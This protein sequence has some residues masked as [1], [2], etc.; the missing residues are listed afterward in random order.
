MTE[1]LLPDFGINE[2]GDGILSETDW[3]NLGIDPARAEEITGLANE[4]AIQ[5][6]QLG[7]IL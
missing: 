7:D 1:R 3:T 2:H 4:L 5:M 6:A